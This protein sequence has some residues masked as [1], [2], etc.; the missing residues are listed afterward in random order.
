MD[1]HN[2]SSSKDLEEKWQQKSFFEGKYSV[3]QRTTSKLQNQFMSFYDSR[4]ISIVLKIIGK[5][6]VDNVLDVGCGC[7]TDAFHVSKCAQHVLGLDI[8]LTALKEGNSLSSGCNKAKTS[9]M[10]SDTEYLPLKSNQFDLVLCKDLLHHVPAPVLTLKEMKRVA[11]VGGHVVAIEANGYNPQMA[12][13]G[14]IHYAVDKGVFKSTGERLKHLFQ[15]A[16]FSEVG[17]NRT[18]FLP[19]AFLFE[20]RSPLSRFNSDFATSS[21]SKIEDAIA[22]SSIAMKFANYLIINGIKKN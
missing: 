15:K 1:N 10:L 18:E 11:K 13:I 20:Y 5:N 22:K 19:R 2:Q 12:T 4:L 16:Q 9:F 21:L 6:S 3:K 14:L 17:V 8:S 7:G